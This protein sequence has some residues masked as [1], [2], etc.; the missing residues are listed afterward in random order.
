MQ[1]TVECATVKHSSRS[2]RLRHASPVHTQTQAKTLIN[3][4]GLKAV[5]QPAEAGVRA[6]WAPHMRPASGT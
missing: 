4:S 5:V 2:N 6:A 3:H 1:N